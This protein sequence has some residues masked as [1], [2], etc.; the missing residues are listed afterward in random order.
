MGALF[1]SEK[2]KKKI[3]ELKRQGKS[4]TE[5][6]SLVE[7]MTFTD[8][9]DSTPSSPSYSSDSSPSTSSCSGGGD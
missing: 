1:N 6:S 4:D 9:A 5:A 3:E 7:S 2:R 8:W